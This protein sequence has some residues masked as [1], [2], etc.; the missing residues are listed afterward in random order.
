M[1]DAPKPAPAPKRAPKPAPVTPESS[2]PEIA[3]AAEVTAMPGSL[4]IEAEALHQH[5]AEV[6]P[7]EDHSHLPDSV[8]AEIAAGRKGLDHHR[9]KANAEHDMGRKI[10]HR[11]ASQHHFKGEPAKPVSVAFPPDSTTVNKSDRKIDQLAK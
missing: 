3:P 8:Q 1:N 2:V 10:V 6:A 11:H 4:S 9:N 7:P 5:T